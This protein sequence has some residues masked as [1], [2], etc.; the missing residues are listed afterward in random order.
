[1]NESNLPPGVSV[2]DIP[3][4]R[5]ADLVSEKLFQLCSEAH[6]LGMDVG[7]VIATVHDAYTAAA[8]EFDRGDT[9]PEDEPAEPLF[10]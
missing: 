6:D 1:M 8:I 9:P 10:V 3:G 7:D 2:S 4:N 5:P